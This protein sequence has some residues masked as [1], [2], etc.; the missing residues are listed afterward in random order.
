MRVILVLLMVAASSCCSIYTVP[1]FNSCG[2]VVKRKK[3][4]NSQLV[5]CHVVKIDPRTYIELQGD[6]V[7]KVGDTVCIKVTVT[8]FK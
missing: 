6:S 3:D 5:K 7:W 2:V 8:K 1:E 4:L